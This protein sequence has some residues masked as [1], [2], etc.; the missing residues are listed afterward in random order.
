MKEG[1]ENKVDI[2]DCMAREG[3]LFWIWLLIKEMKNL[4]KVRDL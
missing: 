2:L 4:G 1:V 3:S